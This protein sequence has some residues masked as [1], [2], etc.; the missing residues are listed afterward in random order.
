MRTVYFLTNRD[1]VEPMP[2]PE[3][4]SGVTDTVRVGTATMKDPPERE[5]QIDPLDT[6]LSVAGVNEMPEHVASAI[7][8]DAGDH[9]LIYIH[10]F[11]YTFRQAMVRAGWLS[12]W[13]GG[14]LAPVNGPTVCYSFPST[15]RLLGATSNELEL[16]GLFSG[17][18]QQDYRNATAS[19]PA[20]ARALPLLAD[21]ARRFK[22]VR[23]HRAVT[24][25]AHS[26]G[27]HVL[28]EGV[29]ALTG[30]EDLMGVFDRL[31]LI[32]ADEAQSAMD[33][34]G[35]L[36][37]ATGFA[38]RAYIYYNRQDLP[39]LFSEGVHKTN[40]LG[41]SGPTRSRKSG[42][43]FQ[44][45]ENTVV[46]NASTAS[47][48]SAADNDPD[49]QRHQYYRL[50]PWV[51]DDLCLVMHRR[52]DD[53]ADFPQRRLSTETPGLINLYS[54]SL[55]AA[56]LQMPAGIPKAATPPSPRALAPTA[57]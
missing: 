41:R 54:P 50:Y 55:F 10:G 49:W 6:I 56:A 40:R 23:P 51:R 32:A 48:P 5:E 35:P 57:V 19:G 45:P 13:F 15:G 30:A 12:R 25:V 34:D 47:P 22:M 46:I 14:G 9:M 28:A 7:A 1:Q 27:N 2:Y 36:R 38:E 29:R 43:P 39:L 18:Y 26:M 16:A 21:L 3:F 31:I 11:N 44:L 37:A 53:L 52:P 20:V 33:A 17:A 4:G 24:V 8:G 42:R